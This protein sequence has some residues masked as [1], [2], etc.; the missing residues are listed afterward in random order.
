MGVD[1]DAT[2]LIFFLCTEMQ[3]VGALSRSDGFDGEALL[4]DFAEQTL[5]LTSL[6]VAGN[7]I[8]AT[9]CLP[10][11]SWAVTEYGLECLRTYYP[12]HWRRLNEENWEFQLARK[13]WAEGNDFGEALFLAKR[14]FASQLDELE[15]AKKAKRTCR[16]EESPATTGKADTI[17]IAS[18]SEGLAVAKALQSNLDHGAEPT[19]WTQNIFKPTKTTIESLTEAAAAHTAGVFVFTPDDVLKFRGE[20]A[21]VARDN[22]LFEL[23]LFIGSIG[24]RRCFIVVP[25]GKKGDMHL[26]TDLAGVGML[27]YNEKRSD[28]NLVAALGPAS[29]QILEALLRADKGS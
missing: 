24:L 6:R 4:R 15:A 17:F 13:P 23:G 3:A 16:P 27:D 5:H 7:D 8:S 1:C 29:D 26:P 28:N 10:N 9:L 20:S 21:D 18:S 14:F 12:I 25:R 2:D 22:V 11:S 19:I